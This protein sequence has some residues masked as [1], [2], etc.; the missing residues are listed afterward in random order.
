MN[1]NT[2]LLPEGNVHRSV[3]FIG[4]IVVIVDGVVEGIVDGV[5]EGIVD[6]IVEGIVDG[7]VEGIVA[8][9]VE[10]VSEVAI[11]VDGV[12][13]SGKLNKCSLISSGTFSLG[14]SR[15]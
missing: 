13:V 5:V 4:T 12:V 11:V 10:G 3:T 14:S 2:F 9:L 6:G 8:E 7:V 15:M 1:A